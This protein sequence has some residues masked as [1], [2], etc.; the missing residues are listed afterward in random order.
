[1]ED[2]EAG[3]DSDPDLVGAFAAL[4]TG[5]EETIDLARA[6]LAAATIVDPALDP[7]SA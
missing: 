7:D 4:T 3:R 1:M 6:S 5:A 2:P